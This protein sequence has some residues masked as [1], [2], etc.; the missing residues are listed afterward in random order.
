MRLVL[1]CKSAPPPNHTL[2][3][4]PSVF[5]EIENLSLQHPGTWSPLPLQMWE[6][7]KGGYPSRGQSFSCLISFILHIDRNAD[8]SSYI[9]QK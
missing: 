2:L 4:K 8:K 3:Y 6:Y 1:F 9:V 5:L 7:G